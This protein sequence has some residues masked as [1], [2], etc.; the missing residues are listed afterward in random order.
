[1]IPTTA[2]DAA[3]ER[4]V[5][6]IMRAWDATSPE[7]IA[8]GRAW[9]S[10]ARAEAEAI[11]S[12]DARKGAGLLAALSANC[13]WPRTVDLARVASTGQPAGHTGATLDRARAILAGAD[14]AGLL[15]AG[16]KTGHFYRCILDPADPAAVTVDRHAHDIA[17]GERYGSRDRGL[18]N[19]NRYA[20]LAR[21]YT[22][23]AQRLGELPS[24][25]QAVTWIYW[26]R[27]A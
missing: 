26:R 23:A 20:T 9:Y 1:M 14:P 7:D 16:A 8:A 22:E 27:T 17:A 15:P 10:T 4:Y 13:S 12:G 19:R 18:S 2:D 3:L 25:V 21:A 24:T 6:N 11:G 5:S